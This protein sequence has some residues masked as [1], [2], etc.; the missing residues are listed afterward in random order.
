VSSPT[1]AGAVLGLLTRSLA[2]MPSIGA[3]DLG[4]VQH[5][6]PRR[7]SSVEP[8]AALVEGTVMTNKPLI[9]AAAVAACMAG[10]QAI[11]AP[12]VNGAINTITAAG[13]SCTLGD[14]TLSNFT[15]VPGNNTQTRNDVVFSSSGSTESVAFVRGPGF[16]SN[17]QQQGFD[18]TV[19]VDP[20]P[21]AA[22][23]TL[24]EYAVHV[25]P[26]SGSGSP[27]STATITGNITPV[28]TASGPTSV[29]NPFLHTFT[30]T[31]DTSARVVLAAGSLSAT[32]LGSATNTFTLSTPTVATPEPMSLALFGLGLAGLGLAGRRKRS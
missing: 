21:A 30:L 26:H 27:T 9:L 10:G 8:A 4:V 24:S 18:F 14:T 23:T 31:G 32:L 12:C 16:G 3:Y 29:A 5:R 20:G 11:A 1:R 19:T 22:G 28:Q 17:E 13:F 6:Q 2:D 25:V 15:F 7:Q